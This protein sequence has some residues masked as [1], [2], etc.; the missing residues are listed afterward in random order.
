ML[1]FTSLLVFVAFVAAQADP[2]INT[3]PAMVQCQPAQIN[4]VA[5]RTP[6]FISVIPGGQAGAAPLHDFGQ[7]SGNSLTWVVNIPAPTQITLQLRDGTGALAYSA[8]I[9]IQPSSDSSCL[10]Q[11]PSGSSSPTATAPGTSSSAPASPSE[12]STP[13]S[14]AASSSSVASTSSVVASVSSAVSSAISTATRPTSASS[15]RSAAATSATP[16]ASAAPNAARSNA[17]VGL[18]GLLG[19]AAAVVIV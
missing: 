15:T 2:S 19:L 8:P 10:G 9:T 13:V 5:S 1:V 14:S 18:A 11:N 16:S 3:P 6:V 12:T 4:W 7:Q 17:K